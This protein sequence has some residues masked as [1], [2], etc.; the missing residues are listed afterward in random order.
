MSMTVLTAVA[1]NQAKR[2]ESSVSEAYVDALLY[3][4]DNYEEFEMTGEYCGSI[5]V[6]LQYACGHLIA[7][8]V[9]GSRQYWL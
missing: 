9:C 3:V 1:M 5:E 6:C 2:E 7:K 8:Q 4:M